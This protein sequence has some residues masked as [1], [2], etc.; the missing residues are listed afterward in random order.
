MEK[1]KIVIDA[2]VIIHFAKGEMLSLLPCIFNNYKYV[3]LETVYNEIKGEIKMQL[4][5]QVNFLKNIE[6]IKFSPKGEVL[7]E[8]AK[9]QRVFGKGESAC[10][11]YCRFNNDVIGS[12]NLKDIKNYCDNYMITYLTTIDFLYYAIK[13]KVITPQEANNFIS[14]VIKKDSR[15][16]KIDMRTFISNVK[17]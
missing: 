16:P 2:D 13:K 14:K 17:I 6:V 1:T 8:Y 3:V 11:V 12:S 4:D 9:L 7:K 10:M 5:N 15:L